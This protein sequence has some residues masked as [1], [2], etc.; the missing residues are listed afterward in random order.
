MRKCATVLLLIGLVFGTAQAQTALRSLQ[1]HNPRT[2]GYHLGDVIEREVVLKLNDPYRLDST[3]LPPPGRLDGWFELSWR[4][5]ED[6]LEQGMQYRLQLS[7]QI[8]NLQQPRQ[9]LTIPTLVLSVRTASQTLGFSVPSL[10]LDVTALSSMQADNSP[11][12]A[13]LPPSPLATAAYIWRGGLALG[14]GVLATVWWL[15]LQGWLPGLKK[16]AG[17]FANAYRC[18]RRE[19]RTPDQAWRVMH[20]A[21]D[22]TANR[23]VFSSELNQLF[24]EQAWLEPQRESI[25]QFF[26]D[27]QT[28]FFDHH[29]L[30]ASRQVAVARLTMLCKACRKLERHR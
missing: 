23:A 8:I 21:F 13:A 26:A 16:R 28:Y 6:T 29:T 12:Q 10:A 11:A 19:C 3:T 25:E 7:Y 4:L 15:Y 2:F 1:I 30:P 27:S 24:R 20:R 14:V 17:P 9:T 18:L 5:R 22:Q